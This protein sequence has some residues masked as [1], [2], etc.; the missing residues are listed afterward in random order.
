MIVVG[1]DPGRVTGL[2]AFE[3]GEFREGVEAKSYDEVV[4]F[5]HRLD[6]D[7]VVIEDFRVRRGQPSDY[8]PSIRMIGVVD[9][10]C[11]RRRTPMVVQSP[12]IL[13]MTLGDQIVLHRSR[14]VRAAAAHV[15]YYT[16]KHATT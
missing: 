10:L 14:H 16:R 9:F 3:D 15:S 1:V 5:I 8:H 11:Q 13:R 4:S 7:V 6:P 2:C 12:S